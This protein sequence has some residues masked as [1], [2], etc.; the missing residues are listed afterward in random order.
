MNVNVYLRESLHGVGKNMHVAPDIPEKKLNNAIS[1]HGFPG[2]PGAV[3][4]V[5]DNTIFG[6][7]KEG[8]L[9]TG[10]RFYFRNNGKQ[11]SAA[12]SEI[13]SVQS[14]EIVVDTEKNKKDKIIRIEKNDD[15]DIQIKLLL[16]PIHDRLAEIWEKVIEEGVAHSEEEQSV[17]VERM[18]EQLKAA[19]GKVIVNMAYENDNHVDDAEFAE[20]LLLMT[21]LG[22]S[23]ESRVELRAYLSDP[24]SIEATEAL[25]EKIDN[26]APP[27]Q[28]KSIHVSLIKDLLHVHLTG[29]DSTLEN[30]EFLKKHRQAFD[31]TDEQVNLAL[32]TIKVDRQL[33]NEDVTDDQMTVLMKGLATRAASVGIP[34]AAVYLTGSVVGLSAT[35]ITSGLATLGM[36][37]LLG[38]SGMVT[39][40]GIVVLLGVGTYAG[41]NKLTGAD[42]IAKSKRRELMLTE[43]V[44]QT[45]K[46]ITD[47]ME[48]MNY[49][50]RKLNDLIRQDNE[51]GDEIIRLSGLLT[52]LSGA[53][54]LLTDRS[55]SAQG[56]ISRIHCAKKLDKERLA[57]LTRDATKRD[58]YDYIAD[59]YE[60]HVVE[61]QGT[62][63]SEPTT[64]QEY[65]LKNGLDARTLEDLAEAFEAI[66]YYKVG[67]VVSGKLS[68]MFKR[69]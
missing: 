53:G 13:R 15:S 9:I 45:Q 5:Y 54:Q 43:V 11:Q 47:F 69:D 19:Y 32:E 64:K 17:P 35:G 14:T 33:L 42:E 34:I 36:G 25:I 16:D 26:Y 48:D 44:K 62:D 65:L 56:G 40:I 37:G 22:L 29:D 23:S 60:L 2:S 61:V 67:S 1:A 12:W 39:G 21:R 57:Q 27:G 6:S 3:I 7:A 8:F 63:D 50:I 52:Q 10:E 18:P 28:I 68:S 49:V 51:K 46:T 38:M 4:A 55:E 20:I 30:F 31:V 59:H 58:F 24:A 66:G 41:M